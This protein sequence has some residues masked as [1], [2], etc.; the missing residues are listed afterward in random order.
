MAVAVGASALVVVTVGVM[1]TEEEGDA[2]PLLPNNPSV[3]SM[4]V[5]V[6]LLGSTI[7]LGLEL[8]TGL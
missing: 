3:G 6:M 7:G 5:A 4:P 8:G 1:L 2:D